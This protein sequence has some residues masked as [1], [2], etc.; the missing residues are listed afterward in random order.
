MSAAEM[1]TTLDQI[2]TN[3]EALRARAE[4]AEKTAQTTETTFLAFQE[5]SGADFIALKG[6]FDELL[7]AKKAEDAKKNLPLWAAD[8]SGQL[9]AVPG[10]NPLLKRMYPGAAHGDSR[11]SEQV[12]VH[13]SAMDKW[14]RKGRESMQAMTAPEQKAL[15]ESIDSQGGYLVP[16]DFANEII[17]VAAQIAE[18]R[19]VANVR[20]T[21]RDQVWISKLMQLPTVAW[22]QESVAITDQQLKVGMEQI[23]INVQT[24]LVLVSNDLLE[25]TEADVFGELSSAFGLKI[26]ES[27][28]FAFSDGTG[29]LQPQGFFNQADLQAAAFV[30][31]SAGLLKGD[32][33]IQGLYKLK[34][35]YRRMATWAMASLI[36]AGVRTLKDTN[37]QYLWQINPY[38][39]LKDGAPST[40]LGRP[41]ISTEGHADV[42]ATG[43]FPVAVGD[44]S[45]GYYVRDRRGLT[46]QRLN[47]RYAEYRQTGFLVSRRVGA[48]PVLAE[49]LQLI[50][51]Q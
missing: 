47:E 13:K 14:L 19:S 49:A 2:A 39:A 41:V 30:T 6:Q 44:F 22:G 17:T 11:T 12:V 46:I 10:A 36:E 48:Q 18:I 50:K 15:A 4:A 1:K 9:Q 24:A 35:V 21:G 42:V 7:A 3:T 25:D 26:A 16:P 32:D 27:E 34:K 31:S 38:T 37:G 23:A 20:P 5:K 33:L 40:I 43:K 51:I 28:D 29:V 8:G 45:R